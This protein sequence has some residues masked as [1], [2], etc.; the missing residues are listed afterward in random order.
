M[1]CR[2]GGEGMVAPTSA[3]RVSRSAGETLGTE[4]RGAGNMEEVI[5]ETNDFTVVADE[6]GGSNDGVVVSTQEMASADG[7]LDLTQPDPHTAN[8]LVVLSSTAEDGE[9]EVRISVG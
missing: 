6:V 1:A 7:S 8:A 4:T 2:G 5:T 3:A 9:I